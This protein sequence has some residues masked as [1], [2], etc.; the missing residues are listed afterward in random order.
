ML[1]QVC[2]TG[3]LS[4]VRRELA[5]EGALSG[6]LL[7]GNFLGMSQLAVPRTGSKFVLP[8][9]PAEQKYQTVASVRLQLNVVEHLKGCNR[10]AI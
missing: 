6:D 8:S 4:G 2:K 7:D 5:E 9:D 10:L 3:L 1:D